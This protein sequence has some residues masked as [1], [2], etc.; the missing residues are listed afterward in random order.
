MLEGLLQKRVIGV[1]VEAVKLV[2]KCFK[3]IG[4]FTVWKSHAM[5]PFVLM[6]I[7]SRL[8]E[9][10]IGLGHFRSALVFFPFVKVL[11]FSR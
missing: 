6:A 4:V 1:K 5:P 2:E 10:S 9:G 8:R 3:R 11:I 7:I